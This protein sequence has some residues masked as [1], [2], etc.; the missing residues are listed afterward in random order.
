M[1]EFEV[2]AP[3][4]LVVPI[5]LTALP[6]VPPV[7]VKLLLFVTVPLILV[8]LVLI[9][10]ALVITPVSEPN[11]EL[12][13]KVTPLFTFTFWLIPAEFVIFPE[14]VVVP[15]PDTA[16]DNVPP[17]RVKALL[18]VTLPL[19]FVPLLMIVPAFVITPLSEP[20]AALFVNVDPDS[21]VTA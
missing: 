12:L 18:L 21:T 6:K 19:I 3:V 5:P 15:V 17:F 4:T 14:I 20:N 10:P 2:T 13:V 16:F 1:A 8:A 7:K 11:V 9:T